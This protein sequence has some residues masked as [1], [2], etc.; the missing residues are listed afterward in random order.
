M[1]LLN[2]FCKFSYRRTSSH[3]FPQNENGKDDIFAGESE[4][5]LP[6]ARAIGT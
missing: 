2:V 6:S 3:F 5:R 1:V 4:N